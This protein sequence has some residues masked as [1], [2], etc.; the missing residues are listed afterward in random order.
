MKKWI[1][2]G[3]T[4]LLVLVLLCGCWREHVPQY[5]VWYCE[6][7]G[8]QISMDKGTPSFVTVDGEQRRCGAEHDRGSSW[9]MMDVETAFG[10][11]SLGEVIFEG[12]CVYFDE[13]TMI[14]RADQTD[15]VFTRMDHSMAGIK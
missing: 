10:E 12:D 11:Y 5:G 6:D 2:C 14:I 9:I 7:A 4:L 3:V 1:C 13:K 15:Y 8:I